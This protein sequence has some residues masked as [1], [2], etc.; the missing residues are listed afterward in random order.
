[1]Q[2]IFQISDNV[3]FIPSEKKLVRICDGHTVKLRSSA[4]FCLL[5]LLEKQGELVSHGEL[6]QY[7]WERFGMAVSLNVLHNT[8]HHLRR[9]LTE[10]GG[11][12]SNTVETI[13]RRGFIFSINTQVTLILSPNEQDKGADYTGSQEDETPVRQPEIHT[14]SIADAVLVRPE[15]A[16]PF[17]IPETTQQ[18]DVRG[19][20]KIYVEN[21]LSSLSLEG[22]N[23]VLNEDSLIVP[24]RLRTA[25]FITITI[26]IFIFLWQAYN[27][28]TFHT[29]LPIGYNYSGDFD[30]C[31]VYQNKGSYNFKKLMFTNQLKPYCSEKRF[32]YVTSY[33][34]SNHVSALICDNK[35]TFFSNDQ[36]Y[37]NY[38]IYNEA[39]DTH[40]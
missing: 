39:G 22:K 14:G 16:V 9:S 8:I 31:L 30:K 33:M 36:C 17:E 1:M 12:D 35:I 4:S 37:S 18:P 32:L 25:F 3:N 19:Q 27:L 7:G 13:H 28:Y 10:V 23:E 20:E 29:L 5:L 26:L 40:E 6:F 34:Y 38:F 21:N 11:F 24:V 15:P 2:R